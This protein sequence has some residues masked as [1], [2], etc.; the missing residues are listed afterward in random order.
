VKNWENMDDK[1][2]KA[3]IKAQIAIEIVAYY[4]LLL[5]FALLFV[6]LLLSY[7]EAE[8]KKSYYN[9]IKAIKNNFVS[10]IVFAYEFEEGF[11]Y[12]YKLPSRVLG[13]DYEI[14]LKN[15]NENTTIFFTLPYKNENITEVATINF[16][17]KCKNVCHQIT[18]EAVKITRKAFNI[19]VV[20]ENGLKK[21]VELD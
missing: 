13:N 8:T 12:S 7:N 2:K 10:A 18:S 17:V 4:S 1:R 11:N 15:D 9:A 20:T 14:I 16:L 21:V 5:F 6:T 19:S 3:R